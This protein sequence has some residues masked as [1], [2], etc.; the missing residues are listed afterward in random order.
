MIYGIK[1][2]CTYWCTMWAPCHIRPT[3]IIFLFPVT[4]WLPG[5]CGQVI[6]AQKTRALQSTYPVRGICTDLVSE[7]SRLQ[8]FGR[9][10]HNS[11]K[12]TMS[13]LLATITC[14]T[15]AVLRICKEHIHGPIRCGWQAWLKLRYLWRLWSVQNDS[16]YTEASFSP[17]ST[18]RSL[19][20]LLR[21][22]DRP[23]GRFSCR[24]QQR[25]DDNRHTNWL[26]YPLRMRAG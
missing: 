6:I 10:Q 1:F 17:I 7:T 23:N 20:L 9:L 19:Y 4:Y 25:R 24:Q 11:N 14:H 18:Y 5:R 15:R 22:L 2:V 13:S 12:G 8:S 16:K 3:V 26:L 21:R